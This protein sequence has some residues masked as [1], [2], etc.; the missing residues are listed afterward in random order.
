[1]KLNPNCVRDM[2]L[3][4]E[5]CEQVDELGM[6]KDFTLKE[7]R[8]VSGMTR[9]EANE[10]YYT[11]RMLTDAGYIAC[12]RQ[13][14]RSGI[15][16]LFSGTSGLTYE[17]HQY[18]ASVRDDRVWKNVLKKLGNIGGTASMSVISSIAE[19]IISTLVDKIPLD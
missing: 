18:L 5:E 13:E 1:M 11:L 2:L 3:A 6:L 15:A 10:F 9:Y 12:T 16:Y 14:S 17:G 8:A 4:F 7:V 19:G